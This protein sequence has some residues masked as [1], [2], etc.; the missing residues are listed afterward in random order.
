MVALIQD[1]IKQYQGAR[2]VVAGDINA[3]LNDLDSKLVTLSFV[4]GL[5]PGTPTNRGGNQLDGIWTRNLQVVNVMVSEDIDEEVTDH[6][7]ILAT[8]RITG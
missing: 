3:Q 8:I 4:P 2:I 5:N 6:N 1:K 7:C